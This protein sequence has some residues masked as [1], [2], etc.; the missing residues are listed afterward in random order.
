MR[1]I[2]V[3]VGSA[4]LEGLTVDAVSVI[5]NPQMEELTAVGDF[6]LDATTAHVADGVRIREVNPR[7]S[8]FDRAMIRSLAKAHGIGELYHITQR[9]QVR[10]KPQRY[11]FTVDNFGGAVPAPE[12]I[13]APSGRSSENSGLIFIADPNPNG[14]RF[15]TGQE[16]QQSHQQVTLRTMPHESLA[17]TKSRLA[18]TI[19]A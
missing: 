16:R 11:A 3:P 9:I 14:L 13:L 19:A 17:P 6:S 15:F 12:S 4:L 5:S 2:A 10:I 8:R 1:R 18:W 7:E